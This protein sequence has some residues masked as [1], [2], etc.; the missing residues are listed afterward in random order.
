MSAAGKVFLALRGLI[1]KQRSFLA[2]IEGNDCAA[3][4]ASSTEDSTILILAFLKFFNDTIY[5]ANKGF[6]LI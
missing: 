1:L 3:L 4:S 2:W 5:A 6:I